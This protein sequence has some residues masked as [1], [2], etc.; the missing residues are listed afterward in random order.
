[1]N[2]CPYDSSG[3]YT[4]NVCKPRHPQHV[5][6]S[7][8]ELDSV[9]WRE[10]YCEFHFYG[11]DANVASKVLNIFAYQSRNYLTASVPVSRLHVYVRQGLTPV[12]FSAQPEP[13]KYTPAKYTLAP[14]KYPP[15]PLKHP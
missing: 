6:P 3:V 14:P 12:H 7:Y 4:N 10:P 11:E 2:H 8:V 1:V 5:I 9:I 13:T 15:T